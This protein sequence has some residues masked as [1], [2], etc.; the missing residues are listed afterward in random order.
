MPSQPSR[1]AEP[2]RTLAE[3]A[4]R[5][6]A[7]C[8]LSKR[9]ELRIG[10]CSFA[11][12][13]NSEAL[14]ERLRRYFRYFP[15]D[16]S[17]ADVTVCAIERDPVDLGLE[18]RD[19]PRE[20]GKQGRKDEYTDVRG[21]RV[22]RK[23]RTGMQFLIGGDTQ[24]AFGPCLRNDNQVVNF[25]N[26]LYINRMLRAG[27]MLCHGAAVTRD[28]KGLAIS[29]SSGGGKSTLALHLLSRGF[30]FV[31]NDRLLVRAGEARA[32][33]SGVPKLPRINP[34]TAMTNMHLSG[35]LPAERRR[36][37]GEIS[38]DQLWG[39]EEKY[40]VFIDE[41]F[42]GARFV[43]RAPLDA[44]V[45]LNWSRRRA[46][47]PACHRVSLAD[48]R[49]LLAAVAKSAGPFFAVDDGDVPLGRGL[50]DADR[51]FEELAGVPVFEICGGVDFER[52][53]RMA[54]DALDA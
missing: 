8:G 30:S 21:G 15:A 26:A 6:R 25:I 47:P 32:Q 50:L 44:L 14:I 33:M 1:S 23:V 39:L 46:E 9:L 37:L 16:G 49:D 43:L 7:G 22:V 19:W 35:L 12:T 42:N 2:V 10:E 4:R 34:G 31:S 29:A 11:I 40:D 45:V 27:W 41:H 24:I 36:Q 28:G 17:A 38:G 51:Y 53:C 13:T 48:R 5:L 20:G 54:I 18:F 52:A 3:L